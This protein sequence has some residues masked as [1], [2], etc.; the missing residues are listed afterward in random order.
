MHTIKRTYTTLT[1]ILLVLAL[2]APATAWGAGVE[3]SATSPATQAPGE[4]IAVIVKKADQSQTAEYLVRSLGGAV[5]N[6]LSIINSFAAEI[7]AGALTQLMASPS[8]TRVTPDGPVERT[9]RAPVP[10]L[11]TTTA[12]N[13]FRETLGVSSLS[14][15]N[16]AGIGVAI[17]DSGTEY[18]SDYS[19]TSGNR[20]AAQK[21]F[22]VDSVSVQDYYGH[23]SHVAGIVG[24]SGA[25]SGGLYAG[26]AP[27]VSILGL[28]IANDTGLS[29]E[30]DV[31]AAL[32]WILENK[33]RYN[34]RVANLSINCAVPMSYHE[35]PL[36]AACEVLWFNGVVVVASA[37]NVS[38]MSVINTIDSAPANDPFIITV[39]ATDEVGTAS[40]KDDKLTSFSAFGVTRDG[41]KKPDV[42][43]P[44]KDIYSLLSSKSPWGLLYPE[45]TAFNKQYIR[46]SG[47]SMAAPMV[48]GV[49]ALLLQ[50]EPNLT[51]DQVKYR[52][53]A[54]A[55]STLRDSTGAY[56]PYVGGAAAVN[57]TTTQSANTG[58]PVSTMLTTG[59]NP[60]NSSVMW[61]SVM[62]NSVMWNSVMWNSV[63][64]NS[65]MWNSVMWNSVMWNSGC[66]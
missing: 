20:I 24:G 16:G 4:R 30:S 43:A 36:D 7:P 44:G 17:V 52:L 35:S 48:S 41:F 64:W 66:G 56:V 9:A 13:Y 14:G 42:V 23:G 18:N 28:K 45:R 29:R 55:P 50:D 27:G 53:K 40:R 58:I 54:T 63:M 33:A 34:I 46:L 39:G 3:Q 26:V 6:D 19:A 25:A 32:Q 65:V 47:T 5:T 22:C 61:N 11:P 59:E 10:V 57:G 62:W 21:S 37:G 31:V 15:L 2:V 49:A 38:S 1:A 12:S 51:P 60:V 8:I